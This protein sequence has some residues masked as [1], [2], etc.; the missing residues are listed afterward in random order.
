MKRT[1]IK[2]GRSTLIAIPPVYLEMLEVKTGDKLNLDFNLVT[3]KI[4]IE[5]DKI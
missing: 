1:L 2:S 4:E 5:K 3:K